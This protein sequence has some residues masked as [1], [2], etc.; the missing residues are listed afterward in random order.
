MKT[1]SP[2]VSVSVACVALFFATP[3]AG[4]DRNPLS[5][6]P[7]PATERINEELQSRERQSRVDAAKDHTKPIILEQ[8]G[9]VPRKTCELRVTQVQVPASAISPILGIIGSVAYMQ[10]GMCF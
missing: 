7:S 1:F 5:V 10:G 8:G 9:A 2:Y 4:Q 3:S 6:H